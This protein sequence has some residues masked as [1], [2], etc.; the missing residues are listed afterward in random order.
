[1]TDQVTDNRPG[2][3]I[4]ASSQHELWKRALSASALAVFVI[5]ATFAGP[6][7]LAI[8]VSL[9]ALILAW[10]WGRMVRHQAFDTAMMVHAACIALAVFLVVAEAGLLAMGVLIVGTSFVVA[11]SANRAPTLSALGVIFIGLAAMAV[12]WLRSGEAGMAAV[13][14]VFACVWAHDTFAMLIGKAVGGPRLWP[15]ISPHKTWAGAI[16][17]LSAST[18]AGLLAQSFLPQSGIIWLMALGFVLGLAAFAGDLAESGLKRRRNVK[19]ASGLIP[20]HGGF[21]DRLDGALA[22]FMVAAV[23][24]ALINT[25]APALGL[26]QG[27]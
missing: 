23:L 7:S 21:L 26:L 8:V 3:A 9:V 11:L 13:L 1:M 5:G 19:N 16:A 10:E 25:D 2:K 17:G 20:G 24:A 6:W 12:V 18:I 15:S 4:A 14:V 27:F 22:S